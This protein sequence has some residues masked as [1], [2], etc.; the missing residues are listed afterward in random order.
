[1]IH[2]EEALKAVLKC[3]LAGIKPVMITGDYKLTACAIADELDI[4]KEGDLILTGADIDDMNEDELAKI[5]DRVSV[6]ARVSPKH[7]L[8][9]VKALKNLDI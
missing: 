7:K 9:I 5:A 2:Q 3:K 1:M 4:Y 8:S 6:F